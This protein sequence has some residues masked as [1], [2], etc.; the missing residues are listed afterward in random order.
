MKRNILPILA[1]A[2]TCLAAGFAFGQTKAAPAAAAPKQQK[3]IR[4]ATL[5][6]VQANKDFQ[7]N[8]QL[9]QTQRQ[10]VVEMNADME[11]EKDAKKK[12]ELKKKVDAALAKLNENN[13]A[14]AK[15]YG[16]SLERNYVME[17]E[18]SHLY[19]YA[20]DEEAAKAAK[21]EADEKAKKAKKK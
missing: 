16:F 14:M 8:L 3:L 9:V 21:L 4:V 10:G 15:A 19:V 5:N 6:G 1:L 2:A 17:I 13:S 18:T 20:T 7:A 12:A 11:K